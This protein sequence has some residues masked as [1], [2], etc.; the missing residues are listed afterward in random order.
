MWRGPASVSSRVCVCVGLTC[1]PHTNTNHQRQQE[2]RRLRLMEEM[3]S[4]KKEA[5]EDEDVFS[6]WRSRARFLAN[7]P[8]AT[9][10]FLDRRIRLHCSRG[11]PAPLLVWHAWRGPSWPETGP[12]ERARSPS[13][14]AATAFKL[15]AAAAAAT[16]ARVS[17]RVYSECVRPLLLWWAILVD[18]GFTFTFAFGCSAQNG[19]NF[20]SRSGA[21]MENALAF[22]CSGCQKARENWP[23]EW[24]PSRVQCAVV[25]HSGCCPAPPANNGP[26][27]LP[28]CAKLFEAR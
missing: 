19:Y 15:V 27:R 8:R 14:K 1:V 12:D 6:T 22:A 13:K 7:F 11:G 20:I 18:C 23:R 24:D 3:E 26:H 4:G 17:A 10:R 28:L 9:A 25:A 16:G 21:R 5:A 2:S